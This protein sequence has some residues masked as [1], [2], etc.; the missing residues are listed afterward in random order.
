MG[1]EGDIKDWS[2]YATKEG[3]N[4]LLNVMK[5][6][7]D[8]AGRAPRQKLSLEDSQTAVVAKVL[9]HLSRG[10]PPQYIM[11]RALFMGNVFHCTEDTL[12]PRPETGLLVETAHEFIERNKRSGFHRQTIIE[13]GTGCGNIAVSLAMLCDGGIRILASDISAPAVGVA[14]L[15]V[16]KYQM[17]SKV[18][19]RCGDLYE[20]FG[21][22]QGNTDMV[23]CNPPY[24]PTSS[25]K[26][27]AKKIIENE[28]VVA[29]DGGPYGIDI[30]RRLVN[31]APAMLKREG[32]LLFEIGEG[33]ERLIERIL[34]RNGAFKDVRFFTFEGKVRVVGAI[35]N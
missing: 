6:Y 22:V 15:N 11:A 29:L 30:F 14:R 18:T 3:R 9:E 10:V 27:L 12:I 20:P 24:I 4:R 13:I 26:K 2:V 5:F 34:Q 7:D 33:Q 25:L 21:D 1:M 16:E 31:G 28:P 8:I 32:V 23:I 19:L 17:D 35:R